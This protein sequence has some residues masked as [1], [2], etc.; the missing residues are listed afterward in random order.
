MLVFDDEDG[1]AAPLAEDLHE[2]ARAARASTER[3]RRPWLPHVT[4]VRFREPPAAASRPLPGLGDVQ[5]VRRRC[6]PFPAA[7]GG[8]QYEVLE[9][10]ALGG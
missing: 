4:V 8:A 3:E 9:S 6:L 7:P 10:V 5:S 1:R 2:P